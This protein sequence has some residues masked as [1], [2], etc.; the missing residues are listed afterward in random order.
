MDALC[1]ILL[2]KKLLSWRIPAPGRVIFQEYFKSQMDV[3]QKFSEGKYI[4]T[5]YRHRH[6]PPAL[7]KREN[8]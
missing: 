7:T 4:T 3:C 5:G 8:S 2:D 6:G 1:P